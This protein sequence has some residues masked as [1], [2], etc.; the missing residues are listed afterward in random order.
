MASMTIRDIDEKLKAKL[1]I[2]AAP[3]R[4]LDGGRSPRHSAHCV[5]H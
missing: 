5:V 2:Q 4:P 1:R 3:A